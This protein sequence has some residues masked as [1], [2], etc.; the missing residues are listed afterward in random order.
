M[1]S[2]SGGWA[3]YAVTDFGRA[4]PV[5]ANNMSWEQAA[6]LPV[7]LQ[8]MHDAIVTNGRMKAGDA[9][10]IQGASSGVGML[11]MKIAKHMGDRLVLVT[12]T[13]AG[14]RPRPGEF[15]ALRR[16]SGRERACPDR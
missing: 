13:D 8:T 14:R 1:C 6:T 11:G 12:D 2:G 7:A 4:S 5:P 16:A 9:V 15:V 3:E 10:L